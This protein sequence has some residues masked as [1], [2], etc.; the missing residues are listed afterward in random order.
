MCILGHTRPYDGPL[1]KQPPSASLISAAPIASILCHMASIACIQGLAF[2]YVQQQE[3]FT[4]YIHVED[5]YAGYENYTIFSVSTFQYIIMA[6]VFSRGKPYR[7]SLLTNHSLLISLIILTSFTIYLVLGP[8]SWLVKILELQIPPTYE[9]RLT[10]LGFALCNFVIAVFIEHG[11]VNFIVLKKFGYD[12]T[13]SRKE[14]VKVEQELASRSEW[15]PIKNVFSIEENENTSIPNREVIYSKG[16]NGGSS[17]SH[18]RHS[19]TT[20]SIP[21]PK[22]DHV[23]R[24]D[25]HKFPASEPGGYLNGH[26]QN[27]RNEI[28]VNILN[29]NARS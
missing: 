4:P 26:L 5:Q 16:N 2:A 15:P 18:R 20:L 23:N 17:S 19:I 29:L 7:K 11:I 27:S 1:V 9:F 24:S 8:C 21:I 22:M 25:S 13:N 3:W 14:H 10:L 12:R 6:I 28:A